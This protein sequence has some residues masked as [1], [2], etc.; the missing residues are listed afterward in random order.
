MDLRE[1]HNESDMLRGNINM[2]F[3]TDDVTELLRMYEF[4][5]KRIQRIYEYH[6][7][8]INNK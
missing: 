3:L 6:V 8:R 7:E 5:Q 1:A 2:M 4:A